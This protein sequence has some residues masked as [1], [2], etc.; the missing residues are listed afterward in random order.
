MDVISFVWE[1]V[2]I[3]GLS[4]VLMVWYFSRERRP[5]MQQ[6]ITRLTG[7]EGD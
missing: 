7:Y 1:K 4:S 3:F 2:A 6:M 5:T